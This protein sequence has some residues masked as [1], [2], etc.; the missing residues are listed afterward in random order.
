[1]SPDPSPPLYISRSPSPAYSP[2]PKSTE[3]T[4][5]RSSA[6]GP[7]RVTPTNYFIKRDDGITLLL[8]GQM[9]EA[10]RP[11]TGPGALLEG[12]VILERTDRENIGGVELKIE[13]LLE[14]LPL[15]GAYSV[16]TVVA[17]SDLLYH[18]SN[19]SDSCCPNSL[20]FSHRFPSIFSYEDVVYPLPPTC[21]ILFSY[22]QLFVKCTYHITATVL[23][24]HPMAPFFRK[25][26]R[27]SVDL[28]YRPQPT[29]PDPMLE[30]P[31]LVL[32]VKSCPEEWIQLPMTS[33]ETTVGPNNLA[34][35]L[36]APASRVFRVSD[37]IPFHLQVSGPAAL[38]GEMFRRR[39]HAFTHPPRSA[40]ELPVR[41]YL[42]RRVIMR[43]GD[44]NARRSIV[45][46]EGTLRSLPPVFREGASSGTEALSWEG[47][48]RCAE[49][50][51]VGSFEAGLV[52]VKD[53]L[54]AEISPPP[55]SALHRAFA[56]Y[57]VRLI[58]NGW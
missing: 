38:I 27:V 36:F 5:Q 21:H 13:G 11:S 3:Q 7:S 25:E 24:R 20:P 40:E 15:P 29:P 37:S 42:L 33:T 35:D 31:S 45:L 8:S 28:D 9:D 16:V 44:K 4:V 26:H 43:V 22:P 32:T 51:T 52:T 1:M 56:E 6:A 55:G 12:Q 58:E 46:G 53:S 54:A 49:D 39:R 2:F 14:S 19:D 17:I 57:P 23:M 10:Q 47:E 50:F 18:F 48:V 41:V 34:C 30:N